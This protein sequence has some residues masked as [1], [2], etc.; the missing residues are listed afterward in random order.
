MYPPC[1]SHLQWLLMETRW[2]IR[3]LVERSSCVAC[4]AH[5]LKNGMAHV[6]RLSAHNKKVVA[7]PRGQ[8]HPSHHLLGNQSQWLP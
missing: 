8:L 1:P 4:E 5:N 6:A 2:R 3:A 7:V